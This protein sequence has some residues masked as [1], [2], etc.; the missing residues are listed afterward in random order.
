MA[1]EQTVAVDGLTLGRQGAAAIGVLA[2]HDRRNAVSGAMRQALAAWYP[3][4]AR[5]P[6]VYVVILRSGLDA[7]FSV[8]DDVR[9]IVSLAEADPGA[10]RTALA[11]EL[12]LCWLTE[13]FSKPTV[14]LIDGAV[15]GTGVGI[16]LYGTHRIAGEGYRFQMPET[17]IGYV[18]DCGVAHA[19][20]HMPHGIGHYLGL[21]GAA[22]G[23]AD[24]FHLG[25]VTHCIARS[26]FEAIEQQLADA[27]PVDPV[28]DGR[29]RDP[30]PAPILARGPRIERYFGAPTLADI[31]ARLEAAAPSDR[32]W[33]A[34]ILAVLR[35]RSPLALALTDQA[36][37]R[38]ASLDI[39][40]TLIQDYR[41]AYHLATHADFRE[42]V[43]A[44]LIDKDRAPKWAHAQIADVSAAEVAKFFT[45]LGEAELDLPSRS[46]MQ[47]ARV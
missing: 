36:I 27:D 11:E 46:E 2:R 39:R 4:L 23:R 37:R 31:F 25:L 42:G 41:L 13:C 24:A 44:A 47:A 9:E 6:G 5:D 22:I 40:A 43:R 30:G 38:A 17:L 16:T 28:L 21:T 3:A 8:G 1:R 35:A 29:H 15:M 45:A 26:E 19:F 32:D 7:T 34:E 12:R 20:A 14:S 33:A 10:A 18:P